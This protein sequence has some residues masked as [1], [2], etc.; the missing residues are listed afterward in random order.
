M[1]FCAQYPAHPKAKSE[2]RVVAPLAPWVAEAMKGITPDLLP[3]DEVPLANIEDFD[4]VAVHPNIF[5]VLA[6]QA[7]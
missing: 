5:G 3:A 4:L 2:G 6:N 7:R 1:S